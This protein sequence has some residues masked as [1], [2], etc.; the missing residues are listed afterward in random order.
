MRLTLLA[1]LALSGAS[2]VSALSDTP[3]FDPGTRSPTI[4]GG[5]RIADSAAMYDRGAYAFQRG[6]GFLA[7]DGLISGETEGRNELAT[8]ATAEARARRA[9]EALETSV[10]LKPG[11]AYAW[12][13]LGWARARIAADDGAI[14][15]LR[16]SW[17]L[18][19]YNR[20]LADTR[21]D[22]VGILTTPGIGV[23]RL[24]PEDLAALQR[25]V[26]TLAR[27]DQATLEFRIKMTPHLSAMVA[28]PVP[29]PAGG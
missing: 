4:L 1:L 14:R 23:A 12:A 6:F 16:T 29:E 26:D 19:P 17:A 10:N 8:A 21:V 3:A 20:Y 22:L 28:L 9:I 18:A 27:F 2:I 7:A 11:N 15:A 13:S 5:W 25:D 24:S